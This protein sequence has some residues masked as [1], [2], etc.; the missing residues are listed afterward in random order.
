MIMKIEETKAF[1]QLSSIAQSI[2]NKSTSKKQISD[3]VMIVK[4]IGFE[5][6]S[7]ITDLPIMWHQIVR[8]LA[9]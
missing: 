5:K 7:S 4:N 9:V 6:W 1:S 2:V 3:A 8:E